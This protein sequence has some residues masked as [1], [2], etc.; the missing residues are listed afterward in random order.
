VQGA[1]AARGRRRGNL[2]HW[3]GNRWQQAGECSPNQIQ[4]ITRH[5][6]L[7]EVA[8]YTRNADR[9]TLAGQAFEKLSGAQKERNTQKRGW[10]RLDLKVQEHEK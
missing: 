9:K 2:A 7:K 8:R 5:A 6:T 10:T 3:R 4:A 1:C